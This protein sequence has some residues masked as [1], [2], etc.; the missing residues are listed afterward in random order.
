MGQR[1]VENLSSHGNLIRPEGS[2]RPGSW[3][4]NASTCRTWA[5]FPP[6]A[7]ASSCTAGRIEYLHRPQLQCA[8]RWPDLLQVADD[9]PGQ[10]VRPDHLGGR[11]LHR[12]V[13][14]PLDARLQRLHVVVRTV[15]HG[16]ALHRAEHGANGLVLARHGTHL[17]VLDLPDFGIGQR[18]RSDHGFRL[19]QRLADR[20]RGL[21]GLH[22]RVDHERPLSH[23]ILQET[24]GAVGPVLALAQVHVQ[25]RGEAAAEGAVHGADLEIVR[26]LGG[27]RHLPARITDCSEPGRS[28]R[29]TRMWPG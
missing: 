20:R 16:D 1:I 4:A 8:H 5:Y 28:I 2:R 9:H 21:V 24:E 12:L 7:P 19:L 13:A 25:A 15:V 3:L 10:L 27:R 18:L 26:C 17:V 11:S 29:N 23:G 14:L 22:R 6:A